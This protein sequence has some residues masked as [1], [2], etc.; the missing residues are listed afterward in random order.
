[1]NSVHN[2]IVAFEWLRV[3]RDYQAPITVQLYATLS[4]L[5][6]FTA[7]HWAS[8]LHEHPGQQPLIVF[9]RNMLWLL[10]LM[11]ISLQ[12]KLECPFGLHE[13]NTNL[14]DCHLVD[15]FE[16]QK[17]QILFVH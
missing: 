11:M 5:V 7:P 15:R 9:L 6:L 17:Q 12:F 14:D 10:M 4:L 16:Q 8:A 3:A 2:L 13:D 1:M